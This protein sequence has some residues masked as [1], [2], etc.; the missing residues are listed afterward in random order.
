VLS[1]KQ[2]MIIEPS[3]GMRKEIEIAKELNI[4]IVAKEW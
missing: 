3:N 4:P 2:G 1:T